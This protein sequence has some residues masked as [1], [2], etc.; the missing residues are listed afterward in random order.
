MGY[1]KALDLILEHDFG[2]KILFPLFEKRLAH[3]QNRVHALGLNQDQP[4]AHSILKTL[5]LEGDFL[6]ETL[7]L[8]KMSSIA[9][10]ILNSRI[11]V[12][13]SKVFDGLRAW[14]AVTL[15]FCLPSNGLVPL[16]SASQ[17]ELVAFAKRLVA[18]QEVRNPVAH[19]QTIVDFVTLDWIRNEVFE[20]I[21]SWKR[22]V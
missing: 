1:A 22:L 7:P 3:F 21:K 4:P 5:H 6:P 8:H 17:R 14:A 11:R 19:R 10:S 13:H 18:I 12:D 2:K 20:L 16:G 9:R 15:L